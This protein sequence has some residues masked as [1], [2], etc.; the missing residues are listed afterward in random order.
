MEASQQ[1]LA[2]EQIKQ[3]KARYFRYMDTKDWIGL[4]TVF[5]HDAVFDAR[6]ALDLDGGGAAADPGSESDSWVYQGGDTIT[7]FVREAISGRR[8]VHHGHGHEIEIVSATEAHG[9]IAME[10][11]VW[12]L[13]TGAPILHGSGHYYETYCVEDGTWR[14]QTSRLTRLHLKLG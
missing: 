10:D 2:I 4:R 1:L 14:I 6:A 3:L 12:D 13:A 7:E 5:S 8:T 11:K 9:V